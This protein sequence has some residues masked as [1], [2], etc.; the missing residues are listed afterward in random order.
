MQ[1]FCLLLGSSPGSSPVF[2]H[3]QAGDAYLSFEH[4]VVD[5]EQCGERHAHLLQ[6]VVHKAHLPPQL[7]TVLLQELNYVF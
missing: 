7:T 5:R 4:P 1:S 6:G 3:T 2:C